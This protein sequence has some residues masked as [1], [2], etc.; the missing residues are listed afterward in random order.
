MRP[1]ARRG[2]AGEPGVLRRL[3]DERVP[4]LL[5]DR[6]FAALEIDLEAALALLR[7]VAEEGRDHQDP[8]LRAGEPAAV[9]AGG[10]A[11]DHG[12][13]GTGHGQAVVRVDGRLELL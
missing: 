9:E 2:P 5:G 10:V 1:P 7:G 13:G 4:R 11:E 12:A 3:A 6:A 8:R